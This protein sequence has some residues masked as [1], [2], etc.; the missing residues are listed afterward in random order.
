MATVQMSTRGS[1][2]GGTVEGQFGIYTADVNG[3]ITADSRD[4]ASLLAAGCSFLRKASEWMTLPNAPAAAN[5]T[6]Y[7]SGALSNGNT[8]FSA[9]P[10]VMRQ[11]AVVI[12]AGTSALTAGN[13]AVTYLGNDGQSGVDNVST[14]VAASGTATIFLSRGVAHFTSGVITGVAGGASPTYEIGS[15]NALALAVDPNAGAIALNKEDNSGSDVAVGT[16]QS[17]SLGCV[18]P[19][20]NP[21]GTLT[22]AWA[23]TYLAPIV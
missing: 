10:D 21:N 7:Y 22:Y 14:I 17:A 19:H 3:N 12:S 15:T 8:M 1:S 9:Q 18:V 23:Y 16:I 5:P 2:L 11:A 13:L 4:V 20:A 6:A